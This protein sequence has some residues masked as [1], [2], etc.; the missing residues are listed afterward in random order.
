[1]KKIN[2]R[3]QLD[4][5]RALSVLA[6]IIYHANL[7]VF[8]FSL[9]SGGYLGVDVFFVLSGYLIT[10]ILVASIYNGDFSF[11]SFYIARIKRIVPALF[12]VLLVSAIAAYYVL[13]PQ[14]F[15]LYAES[16]KSSLLFYSNVHFS[17]EDAYDAAASI[18]KPLLHTWSL[19]L[20][21]QFYLIFPF[22]IY[23]LYLISKNTFFISWWRGLV[24]H[25]IM[26]SP[27]SR[28]I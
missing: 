8:G 28:Q 10:K 24:F 17:A 25:F 15:E 2:Y 23:I 26:Q 7:N 11:A 27:L 22:F 5:L 18:Y 16:L 14:E 3:P 1:M 19:S 4:G 12:F 6:V 21:W 13:L 20:E 9:F